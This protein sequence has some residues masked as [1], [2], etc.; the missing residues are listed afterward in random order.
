MSDGYHNYM[1]VPD[2]VL[3]SGIELNS[4]HYHIE[5][6]KKQ[7]ESLEWELHNLAYNETCDNENDNGTVRRSYR[8]LEEENG[9]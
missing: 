5:K 8:S 9:G 1:P 6:M 4:L 7:I 3:V 2:K